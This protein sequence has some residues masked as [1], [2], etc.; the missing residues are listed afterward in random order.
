M[1]QGGTAVPVGIIVAPEVFQKDTGA[2]YSKLEVFQKD[3]GAN[4][5]E[6]DV[7]IAK[8]AETSFGKKT[9]KV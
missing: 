9:L 4:Y 7:R 8:V 6:I 5:S 1:R 2:D 3:T